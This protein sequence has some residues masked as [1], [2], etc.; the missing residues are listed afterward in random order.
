[1][2]YRRQA[3]SSGT[4]HILHS[5]VVDSPSPP[6]RN[7]NQA[8][9]PL[10]RESGTLYSTPSGQTG[11]SDPSR[12]RYP[13]PSSSPA[14]NGDGNGFG[15][16]YGHGYGESE[17]SYFQPSYGMTSGNIGLGY[18]SSA[19][20]G[21]SSQYGYGGNM[22]SSAFA[23]GDDAKPLSMRSKEEWIA[24]VRHGLD[25]VAR[26]FGDSS[27]L[28]KSWSMAWGDVELRSLILRSTLINL[29]SLLLL[30]FSPIVLSPALSLSPDAQDKAR[31]VGLWYNV[32]LSWPVFVLCFWI[33]A[34]WG[35]AISKRAQILLHPAYRHQPSSPIPSNRSSSSAPSDPLVWVFS[36]LQR[37]LMISDFTL[38]SRTILLVPVLGRPTAFAYMCIINAY[39]CFDYTFT[40]RG[41]SLTHRVI[42]MQER[43]L[44][45]VGFGFPATFLSSFFTPLVNMAIFALIYPF[46]VLQA[47][48]ARPPVPRSSLLP[49]TPSPHSSL[50]ASPS[51]QH[52]SMTPNASSLSASRP[53]FGVP[54]FFFAK[55][56]LAALSYVEAAIGRHRTGFSG[57]GSSLRERSGK[58]V[59]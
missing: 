52:P 43:T 10:R 1:M 18:G 24:M 59:M 34:Y 48:L 53:T 39:Y 57:A 22:G 4:N 5:P 56:A 26:G 3:G 14:I 29:V 13:I 49:T 28:D 38:M 33:N 42:F 2:L 12:A 40:S 11:P 37:L 7:V 44:Y 19:N 54:I 58:R 36:T 27:R 32:L 30:S 6:P 21:S 46:F 47:L 41:W 50:P 9:K 35:P 16:G 31:S 20:T 51:E 17:P 23:P 8:F 25:N 15:N 55:F 45:M